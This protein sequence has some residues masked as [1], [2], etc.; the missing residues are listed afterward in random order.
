MK[1]INGLSE[2]TEHHLLNNQK[3]SA[4]DIVV[5]IIEKAASSSIFSPLTSSLLW[6]CLELVNQGTIHCFSETSV[7]T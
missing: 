5:D 4:N 3:S 7:L 2:K 1:T 6:S